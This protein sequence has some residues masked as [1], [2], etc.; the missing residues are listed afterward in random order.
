MYV[1]NSNRNNLTYVCREFVLP[2]TNARIFLFV[3]LVSLT[4]KTFCFVHLFAIFFLNQIIHSSE[5]HVDDQVHIHFR[6]TSMGKIFIFAWTH[7]SFLA[8][9]T[10]KIYPGVFSRT[11]TKNLLVPTQI[12]LSQF[13]WSAAIKIIGSIKCTSIAF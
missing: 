10:F 3:N 12:I 7:S 4:Y 11:A 2:L 13:E 1:F 6:L 9:Q 8:F 5:N